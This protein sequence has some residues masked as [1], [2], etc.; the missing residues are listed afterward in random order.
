MNKIVDRKNVT[1]SVAL[2]NVNTDDDA[3]VHV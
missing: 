1:N 2:L 3:S